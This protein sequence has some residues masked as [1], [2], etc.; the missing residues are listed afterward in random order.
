M[1]V[2][3][4]RDIAKGNTG[5]RDEFAD[6]RKDP[7]VKHVEAFKAHL[8]YKG[9]T[10]GTLAYRSRQLREIVERGPVR[11]LADLGPEM[12]ERFL[13]GL[14]ERGCCAR[15]RNLYLAAANAFLNWAV[16]KKRIRANPLATLKRVKEDD[17]KVRRALSPDELA[18]LLRAARERPVAQSEVF[19]KGRRRGERGMQLRPE[20]R[21]RLER[22]GRE[23][24]LIYKTLALTGL[25]RNELRALEARH[26]TLDGPRPCLT[27]P[28][29]ATKNRMEAD[30]PLR[31]DLAA[32]LRTWLADEG[33]GGADRVFNVPKWLVE[34]LKRDLAWAGIPY[35]DN[36]GRAVDIHSLRYTTA[37]L[38]ALGNV[39]PKIA[40]EFMRHHDIRLTMDIY[41]DVQQLNEAAALAALPDLPLDDTG[42]DAAGSPSPKRRKEG[43]G[44]R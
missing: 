5:L 38:L 9:V 24:A 22:N 32:N 31:A 20:T 30:I 33:K 6:H 34:A 19:H 40:Q 1:M 42:G 39:P 7:I 2:D 3:K 15:T 11:T 23:R 12:M 28:G 8:R 29:T 36:R 41:T 27:L 44:S 13:A 17:K 10:A 16:D 18:R 43:K 14:A 35:R 21:A 37:T 26:L 4:Q 25:R